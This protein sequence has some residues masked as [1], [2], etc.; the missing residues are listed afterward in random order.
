M[1]EAIAYYDAHYGEC[2]G[3]G[4]TFSQ[5]VDDDSANTVDEL[6]QIASCYESTDHGAYY[7]HIDCYRDSRG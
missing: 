4:K 7:C 3:C 2:Y 5:V 1:K 6:E